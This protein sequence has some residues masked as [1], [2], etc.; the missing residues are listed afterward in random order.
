MAIRGYQ[1]STL[2][3]APRVDM[4]VPP[5]NRGLSAMSGFSQGLQL[6]GTLASAWDERQLRGLESELA[7]AE[8]PAQRQAVLEGAGK[9]RGRLEERDAKRQL[10]ALNVQGKQELLADTQQ[11][12]ELQSLQDMVVSGQQIDENTL[13]PTQRTAFPGLMQQF[14]AQQ[15]AARIKRETELTGL[16]SAQSKLQQDQVKLAEG[17]LRAGQPTADLPEPVVAVAQANIARQEQEA[18]R[19]SLAMP[20]PV[21]IEDEQGQLVDTG[22]RTYNNQFFEVDS[23]NR[24]VPVTRDQEQSALKTMRDILARNGETVLETDTPDMLAAAVRELNSRKARQELTISLASAGRPVE[25]FTI[26]PAILPKI[27]A[28][29]APPVETV[30]PVIPEIQPIQAEQ[31][32]KPKVNQIRMSF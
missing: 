4:Y 3:T 21:M 28:A 7:A 16:A 22:L 8:T 26:E 27:R 9:R 32:A 20:K 12:R 31:P 1:L 11:K 18:V 5:A 10:S 13:T 14:E 2:P 6:G 17:L 29:M 19:N 15:E 30:N 25:D 24:L 23:N